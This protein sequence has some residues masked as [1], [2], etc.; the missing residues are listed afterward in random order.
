MEQ[1]VANWTGHVIVCGL[2]GVSL[3]MVEQLHLA[4]VRVAVV[5]ERADPR[6]TRLARAWGVPQILGDPRLVETLD[7]VGIAGASSVVCV[8]EDDLHTLETALLARELRQD[9][10]VVV[11]IRN[12]A[13]GRALADVDIAVLDVAGIS[14]PSIVEACLRT[15]THTFDL[16][17]E[18]F[19]ATGT[20]VE[21]GGTVRDLF[22]DLAPIAVTLAKDCEVALCPG[23]DHPVNAGDSVTVLGTMPELLDAGIPIGQ[24][25]VTS[26]NRRRHVVASLLGVIDRRLIIV[27]ACLIILITIATSVLRLGYREADGTRMT[28]LDAL[29]FT[30]E[31]IATVGYG[32]FNFRSQPTGWL[33]KGSTNRDG[34]LLLRAADQPLREQG[35]R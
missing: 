1:D 35:H 34:D 13:V 24:V 18:R 2:H 16:C 3:L 29:Y 20:I 26:R 10:R 30:V 9:V 8:L 25:T 21:R 32:D 19:I 7:S 17:G 27:L 12:P 4:G 22:G 15:G 33:G 14:A 6:L 11:Q 31:T 23:R 28:V 5:A